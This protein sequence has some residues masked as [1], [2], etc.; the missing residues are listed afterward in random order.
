MSIAEGKLKGC[1]ER[2][3][4][5]AGVLSLEGF[6]IKIKGLSSDLEVKKK[7][8]ISDWRFILAYFKK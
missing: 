3:G 6:K 5:V 4:E 1:L 8:H 7:V 2:E